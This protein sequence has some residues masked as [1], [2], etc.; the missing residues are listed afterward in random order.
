MTLTAQQCRMARAALNIGVREL[1]EFA[2]VSPNTIARLER[3]ETLHRR[4]L[5]HVRGVLEAEGV[6]FVSNGGAGVWPGPVVG[7]AK[8]SPLAGRAKLFSDLWNLPRFR[9]EP[10][11]AYHALLNIF[12][13]YLDII[14]AEGREPDTWERL[15]LNH[16][17][18][19]FQKSDV[20]SAYASIQIG[21]T[22]PDNQSKDYPINAE[23]AASVASCDLAYF[24]KAVTYLRSKGYIERYPQEAAMID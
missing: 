18:N 16:G 1:A 3:G 9:L 12:E 10:A 7:Y 19:D 24:R 14:Q 5:A 13:A 17:A 21:I 4:T 22:P 2:D 20:Y 15:N 8:G 6:V 23:T 11:A